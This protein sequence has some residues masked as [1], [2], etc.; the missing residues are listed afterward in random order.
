[1]I[2]HGFDPPSLLAETSRLLKPGGFFI[3]SFDYWPDKID[4]TGTTFFGMDWLIFSRQDVEQFIELASGFGL[5]PTGELQF[6]GK[7][8]AISCA[9]KDYTFATLV[10]RKSV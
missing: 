9:G 5:R 2:E 1:M 8:K 7:E 4:T 3:A 6:L 10:M